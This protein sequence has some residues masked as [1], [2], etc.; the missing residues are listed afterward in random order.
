MKTYE[1]AV[2]NQWVIA[3]HRMAFAKEENRACNCND[4]K[5]HL[6]AMEQ[7]PTQVQA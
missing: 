3:Y 2:M 1:Q 6:A 7:G 4:C 5:E